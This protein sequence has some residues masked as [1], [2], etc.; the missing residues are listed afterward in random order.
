MRS[1]IR[2]ATRPLFALTALLAWAGCARPA[3]TPAPPL[4][5]PNVLLVLADDLGY[6]DSR[7]Y[8]P[9][10]KIAM[11]HLERLASQGMRFTDFHSPAAV[12]APTRYSLATGNYPWRGR[13]I[14]GV[15]KAHG[16]PQVL[17]GQRTLAELLKTAGYRTAKVGKHHLGGLFHRREGSGFARRPEEMDYA[18]PF[19][20]GPRDRGFD[21]SYIIPCGIQDP[22]YAFFRDDRLEGDPAQL[23]Q[24]EA[25]DHG[26]SRIRNPGPGSPSWDSSAVGPLVLDEALAFLASHH[27]GNL[28]EGTAVPFFLYYSAVEAHWPWTPAKSLRGRPVRGVT[29]LGPRADLVHQFDLAL[30]ELI[31]ALERMGLADN[32]LVVVTSDNGGDPGPAEL[33]GGHSASGELLG[34]KGQIAEG[35]HRIPFVARWGDGSSARSRIAPGSVSSQ[36]LSLQDLSAT[37]AELVDAETAGEQAVDSFSF[38]PVLLGRQADSAPVRDHLIVQDGRGPNF[39]L[40][41]GEWKLVLDREGKAGELFK[42]DGTGAE[43]SA[44]ETLSVGDYALRQAAMES[45]FAQLRAA[46]RTAPP[47]H[48]ADRP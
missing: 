3:Q 1:C 23:R 27:Q 35:G 10:S 34:A 33:D 45:R 48:Q 20:A 18:R 22:P 11:P 43:P 44:R 9:Q 46:T 8:N 24:W 7:V 19:R 40:R 26:D 4:P 41:E 32:T 29:G 15:W 5:L 42:L 39:A 14:N 36:L 17:P 21:F 25:G 2:R 12:C 6:G 38:L 37:L 28:V 47:A 30:G 16:Q 31:S 13:Y